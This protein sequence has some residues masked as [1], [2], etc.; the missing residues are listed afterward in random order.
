MLIMA[1]TCSGHFCFMGKHFEK[2]VWRPLLFCNGKYQVS[3]SG[4][5]KS[6]YSMSMYGK[7]RLTGTI[8]KAHISTRGYEKVGLSWLE[9]GKRIK[10]K[11]S[12]H[13]LVCIAF[14]PNPENKPQVNHKDLNQLNNFYKN[15][16]WATAKENTNHAQENGR[17]PIAKP[18][19]K[20]GYSYES[21]YKK[22]V[23][24]KTNEIFES[25]MHL[26]SL[27]GINKRNITRMLSGERYNDTP[28]RYVGMEN[29]CKVR[30]PAKPKPV[31]I[32]KERPPKKEYIPHPLVLKKINQY[33]LDGVFIKDFKSVREA[34]VAVGS[35][36][37]TFRKAIKK[38]PNN[39]TKGF[40]WKYAE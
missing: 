20:K 36:T 19:V 25:A 21:H 24:I 32:K 4:K 40:I 22:V 39:F 8:L 17:I 18:Y 3:R 29:I 14:W 16:E 38:S 26:S 34:A 27:I 33:G 6:V 12:V 1:G 11:M 9:N 31:K 35:A 28:Y 5:V 10:K 23:N 15:L 13:R 37:D 7:V 30:P 2:D